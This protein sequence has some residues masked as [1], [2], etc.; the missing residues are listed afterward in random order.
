M[1]ENLA[2][3][4]NRGNYWAYDNIIRNVRTYGYL[5]DWFTALEACPA[6]WHLP[7]DNEWRQ[8]INFVGRM[9]GNGGDPAT[10]LKAGEGWRDN[11][12]GT[13]DFGFTALPGGGRLYRETFQQL[14]YSGIWWSGTET[15]NT[16]ALYWLMN[17]DRGDVNRTGTDKKFGLSVRCIRDN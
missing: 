4:P 9:S 10:K 7:D 12:N 14:G 5:Y 2:F 8:L 3:N 13:D 6:G 11:G 1:A 16:E 15:N 17:F